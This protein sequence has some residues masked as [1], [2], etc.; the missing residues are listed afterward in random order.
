M[1]RFFFFAS[2]FIIAAIGYGRDKDSVSFTIEGHVKGLDDK[3]VALIFPAY[4][5]EKRMIAVVRN[6]SFKFE[7]K[8]V[9]SFILAKIL[10]DEVITNSSV[11]YST[12]PLIVAPAKTSISFNA[13]YMNGEDAYYRFEDLEIKE[14][15]VSML[16]RKFLT[17]LNKEV[18]GGMQYRSDSA[19]LDSMNRVVLPERRQRFEKLFSIFKDS[20]HNEYILMK[21]LEDFTKSSLYTLSKENK[22]ITEKEKQFIYNTYKSLSKNLKGYAENDY[23]ESFFSNF[24]QSKKLTFQDFELVSGNKDKVRLSEIIKKNK[25]TVLYFWWSGCRPCLAFMIKERANYASLK[26]RNIEFISINVDEIKDRWKIASQKIS[27]PWINLYA[28]QGSPMI[29]SYQIEVFPTKVVFNNQ[30]EIVDINFK[31]M[32]DLMKLD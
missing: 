2:F 6:G 1:R 19:Y 32:Q 13:V 11:I 12:F 9:D 8:M 24:I 23:W 20:I 15:S 29:P 16:Y 30:Y 17:Q 31:S 7:G 28:G 10:L 5:L 26:K 27:I 14:G 18:F 3:K 21:L 22:Y 4:G 25:Y